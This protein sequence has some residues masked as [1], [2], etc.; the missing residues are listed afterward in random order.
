MEI[1]GAYISTVSALGAKACTTASSGAIAG[2]E[3]NAS[4]GYDRARFVVALGEFATGAQIA[5]EVQQ[6]ATT[7][8]TFATISGTATGTL[9][10]TNANK[11]IVIDVPVSGSKPF[12]K[13]KGTAY[14][15]T[16][17]AGAICDLYRGSRALPPVTTHLAK[18]TVL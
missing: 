4:G 3:V 18:Y 8:G 7:S 6:A 13:L 10:S 14:T 11:L 12:I 17:Y 5:F 16:V 1:L 2:T 15:A 9:A